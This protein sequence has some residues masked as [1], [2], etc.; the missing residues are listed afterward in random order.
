MEKRISHEPFWRINRSVLPL[1]ITWEEAFPCVVIFMFLEV[2][3]GDVG[4]PLVLAIALLFIMT[5]LKRAHRKGALIDLI[6]FCLLG[7]HSYVQTDRSFEFFRKK[8]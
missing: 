8:R 5:I 6:D 1:G 3:L 4:I 7:D 2:F